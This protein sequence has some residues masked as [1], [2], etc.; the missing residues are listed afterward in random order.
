M[1]L[2][3]T[4]CLLA[5]GAVMVYSASSATSL[6]QGRGTGSA[7]LIKFLVYGAIVALVSIPLAPTVTRVLR[8]G[9]YGDSELESQRAAD[10][11]GRSLGWQ[12]SGSLGWLRPSAR[13]TWEKDYNNDDRTVRAGLVTTG[14]VG[15]GLP[16][17]RPDDNYVLFDIGASGELGNSKVTGFISVNATAGKNDGNYQAVTVGVRVPL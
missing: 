1:L 10:V 13:V 5:F 15:F 8:A 4:L 16:A 9:G 12:A 17:L 2:T 3:A 6:L 11:L 7:Y 14:G